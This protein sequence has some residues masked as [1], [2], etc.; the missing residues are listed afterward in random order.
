MTNTEITIGS[1]F[2]YEGKT[3]EVKNILEKSVYAI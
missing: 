2:D 3:Y 1:L